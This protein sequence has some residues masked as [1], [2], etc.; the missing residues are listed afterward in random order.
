MDIGFQLHSFG[1]KLLRF[2]KYIQEDHL[3]LDSM[4]KVDFYQYGVLS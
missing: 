2:N 3:I 1:V 4:F